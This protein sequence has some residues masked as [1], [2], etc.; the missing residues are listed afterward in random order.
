MTIPSGLIFDLKRYAINDG[1][2]IRTTVFLKG[3]PLR[4]AWCHNPESQSPQPELMFRSNRCIA[5]GACEQ[6]CKYDAIH[7]EMADQVIRDPEK[8]MN[9]G[10]CAAACYS[11]A[12]QWVGQTVTPAQLLAEIE[13]DQAFYDASGGGVTFSGGEPL[14]QPAF[15]A[16]TLRLC[17]AHEIHTSVDTCG[18]AS[19]AKLEAL[20]GLV[21]LYLYDLKVMD[22]ARH[23]QHTGVSNRVI[24]ENIHRLAQGGA[25]L[26]IRIPLVAG[27]NDDAGNLEQTAVFLAK[28][29]GIERVDLA[30]Y[31]EIGSAKYS[32]LERSQPQFSPPGPDTLAQAIEIFARYGLSAQQI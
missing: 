18:Y 1:P 2:G 4:C 8:C 16:E 20:H 9:C 22:D 14:L 32:A 21:D 25:H 13:R 11:E 15:L 10:D 29:P 7:M 26:V 12:R 5:C 31:H 23:R 3:C 17:K 19:W 28:L 24:L 27:F 6:A 30:P